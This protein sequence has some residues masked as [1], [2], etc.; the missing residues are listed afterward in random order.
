MWEFISPGSSHVRQPRPLPRCDVQPEDGGAEAVS[1]KEGG[2]V[3]GDG[4]AGEEPLPLVRRKVGAGNLN[5]F[6]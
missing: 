1:D 2:A 4:G 3:G 6:I 5:T